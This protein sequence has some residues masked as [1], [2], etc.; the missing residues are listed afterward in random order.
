MAPLAGVRGW[1]ASL[2][3]R[4]PRQG[5]RTEEEIR[6]EPGLEEYVRGRCRPQAAAASSCGSRGGACGTAL[7]ADAVAAT[8]PLRGGRSARGEEHYLDLGPG[9]SRGTDGDNNMHYISFTSHSWLPITSPI[10]PRSQDPRRRPLRSASAAAAGPRREEACARGGEG[11]GIKEVVIAKEERQ[12]MARKRKG[13]FP[14]S[15]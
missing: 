14:F 5:E 8:T 6:A 13:G 3:L 7:S 10:I 15:P 11:G 1:Y 4:A 12:G 9:P 2:G